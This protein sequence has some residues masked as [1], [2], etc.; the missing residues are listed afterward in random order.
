LIQIRVPPVGIEETFP[1]VP[2]DAFGKK[3]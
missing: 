3:P 2:V 1:T